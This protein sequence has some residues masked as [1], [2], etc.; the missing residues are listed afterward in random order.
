MFSISCNWWY[1]WIFGQS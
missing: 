1:Y